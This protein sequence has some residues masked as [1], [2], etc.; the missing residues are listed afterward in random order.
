MSW[1][2]ECVASTQGTGTQR[3]QVSTSFPLSIGTVL[4]ALFYGAQKTGLLLRGGTVN[5]TRKRSM[6][7]N[8]DLH[9]LSSFVSLVCAFF[10][11]NKA[12]FWISPCLLVGLFVCSNIKA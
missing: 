9:F 8:V 10:S 7:D 12:F 6:Y 11:R 2:G 5:F 3:N 4:S 1:S